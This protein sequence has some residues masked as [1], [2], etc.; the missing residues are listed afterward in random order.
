MGAPAAGALDRRGVPAAVPGFPLA[1]RGAAA[2]APAAVD[3]LRRR[4]F[5]RAVG[6]WMVSS[7]LAGSGRVSVSPV[8]ARVSSHARD[9]DLRRRAVERAADRAAA[10]KRGAGAAAHR[11]ACRRRSDAGA[12][13]SR[14]AGRRT[15]CRSGLQYLA[16]DRR[17]IR[18]RSG[19]SVV[20][21]SGLAQSV[22]EH[23]HRSVRSPHAGLCRLARRHAARQRRLAH[24]ARERRRAHSGRR[25]DAANRARHRHAAR[26]GADPARARR[27]RW[28]A[29]LVFTVAVVHAERLCASRRLAGAAHGTE[30]SP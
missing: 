15:R 27:T 11:R 2:L 20:P 9:R 1:R 19:A 10:A 23:A 30:A 8:P 5:S 4:R 25:G 3:D 26:A 24:A 12:D 21:A 16:A 6:W 17:R 22:R 13:L 28:L 29:I 14:R 7:G 18:S